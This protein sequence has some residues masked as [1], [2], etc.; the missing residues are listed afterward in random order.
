M[1]K[2]VRQWIGYL[3]FSLLLLIFVLCSCQKEGFA[4][5]RFYEDIEPYSRTAATIFI[6]PNYIKL[7][8]GG[9]GHYLYRCRLLENKIG[10]LKYSC[11]S[12]FDTLQP[13]V[14]DKNP[15]AI[16]Y[17]FVFEIL[18]NL[19]SEDGGV[20][21]KRTSYDRGFHLGEDRYW[22]NTEEQEE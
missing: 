22:L 4:D 10:Y 1:Q 18:P 16:N 20:F 11:Y 13:R 19:S 9:G 7:C 3:F 21:V 12:K 17:E 15:R 6:T 2:S 14:K 5:K 8:Y